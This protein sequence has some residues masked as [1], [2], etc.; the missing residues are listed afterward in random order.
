ML[1]YEIPWNQQ[2]NVTNL[3]VEVSEDDLRRKAEMLGAYESQVKLG[4]SYV[5]DDFVR[6]A[7]V[8]RGFQAKKPLAEA[9]E[10][11]SMQW[12]ESWW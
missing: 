5:T 4:R 12:G 3:F 11:I 1:G 9:Y 10:V 6:S 8:F 7:A 2:Q